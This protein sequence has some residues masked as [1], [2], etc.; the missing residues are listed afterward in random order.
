LPS[1]KEG[2]TNLSLKEKA[3][4]LKEKGKESLEFAPRMIFIFTN[5]DHFTNKGQF[6]KEKPC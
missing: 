2:N 6:K 3:S 1:P 4:Q 5:K